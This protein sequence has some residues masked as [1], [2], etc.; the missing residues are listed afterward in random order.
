MKIQHVATVFCAGAACFFAGAAAFAQDEIS[1][2]LRLALD[3]I[4]AER[5]EQALPLFELEAGE[6]NAVA[7]YNLGVL[8]EFGLGREVD[9]AKA[10]E[11]Y[12]AAQTKGLPQAN[13]ALG[14]IYLDGLAETGIDYKLGRD[15]IAEAA[16]AEFVP[17]YIVLSML[18]L[19]GAGGEADLAEAH[20]WA[21]AATAAGQEV[22]F[23]DLITKRL[24]DD[25]KLC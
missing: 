22:S 1:Q 20:R 2:R 18:W 15:L 8:N 4:K 9:I 11:F 23:A 21:C 3:L 6:G 5:Y 7:A 12:T 16:E 13:Y 14:L 10:I 17:S 25:Q 24:N 19:S